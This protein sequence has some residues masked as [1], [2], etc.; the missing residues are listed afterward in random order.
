MPHP[1]ADVDLDDDVGCPD[2][3]VDPDDDVDLDDSLMIQL[4]VK[5]V[6]FDCKF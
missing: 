6:R 5:V 1:D 4:R 2:A 3:D